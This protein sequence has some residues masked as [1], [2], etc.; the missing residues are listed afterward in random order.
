[1]SKFDYMNFTDGSWYIEFVVHAKKFSKR[2]AI[3]LFMIE[4]ENLFSE[5]Y[6]KPTLEDV[7]ERAVRYYPI[8]PG[9]CDFDGGCYSY[10]KS[11]EKGSFPV[12]VIEFEKLKR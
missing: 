5:G 6:R 8:A 12:W 4:N 11:G 9:D 1:M 2:E 10:C 3:D 7:M